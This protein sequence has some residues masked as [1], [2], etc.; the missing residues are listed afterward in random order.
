MNYKITNKDNYQKEEVTNQ[1]GNIL[2][3]KILFS[4]FVKA[5]IKSL[6]SFSKEVGFISRYI[7][8]FNYIHLQKYMIFLL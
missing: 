4:Y 6:L 5:D 8:L 2:D 1:I 7:E 3:K